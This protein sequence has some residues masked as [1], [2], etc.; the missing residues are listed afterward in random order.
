MV[1]LR[2]ALANQDS[3]TGFVP[4]MNYWL[5][6]AAHA[7]FWDRTGTSSITQPPMFGHALAEAVLAGLE[8]DADLR[9][10]A[11]WGVSY[12][13]SGRTSLNGLACA[14]HPWETG[15]DD[16]ARWDDWCPGGFE[17]DRWRSVKFDV[18]AGLD[19][20]VASGPPVRSSGFTVTSVGFNA[21]IAWNAMELERIGLAAGSPKRHA[22]QLVGALQKRWSP[23]LRTWTD[24]DSGSGRVRTLDGLLPLLVDPRSEAFDELLDPAAYGAEFGPCGVHRDEPTFDPDTYWRGPNWPQLTYLLAVAGR[25]AGRD[26]V[27]DTLMRSLRSAALTSGFAEFWNPDTG[28]GG[29]A[30]PQTWTTLAAVSV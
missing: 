23:A 28:A 26:D 2:S 18:V 7:D 25:R 22:A 27:A 12:L 9:R 15:C 24:A 13:L 21:L 10:R 17:R 20:D 3:A 30:T 5:D 29:G 8:V 16:S 6:P 1:E 19:F 14:Y 4:H 11:E